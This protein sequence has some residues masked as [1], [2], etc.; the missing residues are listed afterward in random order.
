MTQKIVD[1]IKGH[2]KFI[3]PILVV[4]LI[5]VIIYVVYKRRQ[6]DKE[7]PIL[8]KKEYIFQN[9]NYKKKVIKSNKL[10]NIC[11]LRFT[12]CFWMKIYG[13]NYKY[14]QYKN[15]LYIG[16]N[17]AEKTA[18]GIWLYPKE[19]NLAVRI[20]CKTDKKSNGSMN[21]YKQ[22]KTN[23]KGSV[24]DGVVVNH[25]CDISNVPLQAW[26]MVGV[27]LNNREM[28]IYINGKLVRSCL[29]PGVPDIKNSYNMVLGDDGAFNGELTK[30]QVFSTSKNPE[31]IYSWYLDGPNT[32]SLWQQLVP[33]FN[34]KAKLCK[35]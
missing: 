30:V 11:G 1:T 28:D 24:V 33:S 17:N 26:T 31:Q 3:V 10:P 5:I 8:L 14:N 34:F 2:Q 23:P 25:E 15:V 4:L 13:Y 29:L 35:K 22:Y 6:W 18:P 12:V 20:A 7:N 9:K 19:N 21:L 27:V 32:K 16:T